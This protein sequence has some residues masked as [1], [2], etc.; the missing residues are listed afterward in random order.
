MTPGITDE[1]LPPAGD[2]EADIRCELSGV[3]IFSAR[4]RH[5]EAFRRWPN[6]PASPLCHD[7]QR[8]FDQFLEGCH[9][10]GCDRAVYGSM[11]CRQGHAK[12]L[13]GNYFV[14]LEA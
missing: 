2:Q 3:R 4:R 14:V 9:E 10:L 1:Q 8:V 5:R 11:V 13:A 12:D 7:P 6:M